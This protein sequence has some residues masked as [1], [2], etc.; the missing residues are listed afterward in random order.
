MKKCFVISPI[1]SEKSK[2]RA[3]A[4]K[5][6]NSIIQPALSSLNIQ[7]LRAD[8]LEKPGKI[9]DQMFTEIF[10][11]DLCIAVL[12]G[13]NPNVFYE[14]AIAQGINKPIIILISKKEELP[15][16]IKDLRSISYEIGSKSFEPVINKIIS[17]VQSF[18]KE[19]WKVQ[20]I[21]EPYRHFLESFVDPKT[22]K[23]NLEIRNFCSRV[24]G[25]W[26]SSGVAPGTT[27]LG[28]VEFVEDELMNT[29]SLFGRAYNLQGQL[30]ATWQT[31][32]SCINLKQ[33]RLYYYWEG[34]HSEKP[35]DRFEG[36]GEF[37][38][39]DSANELFLTGKNAFFDKNLSDIKS[40]TMKR[41]DLRRCSEE[42]V[43]NIRSEN[44]GKWIASLVQKEN[45]RR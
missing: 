18:E 38:F 11:A 25:Y 12:T 16:D 26:L 22:V 39:F 35:G 17:F 14:L 45:A 5:V 7:T 29:L 32:A 23:A 42:E 40:A 30:I 43:S 2:I 31:I 36:F 28:I 1:G 34:D 41:S 19:N 6:L 37:T 33:K 13:H 21:F 9:T 44:N 3:H 4:D 24:K 15:F 20:D 10:N 27:S 8:H